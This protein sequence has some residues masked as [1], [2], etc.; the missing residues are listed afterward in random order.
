[1]GIGMYLATRCVKLHQG[2]IR[3]FSHEH[4]GTHFRVILPFTNV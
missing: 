3:V 4:E 2:T 1:M